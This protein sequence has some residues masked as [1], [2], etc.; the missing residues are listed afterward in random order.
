MI[1]IDFD[2]VR[3]GSA[4]LSKIDIDM[5]MW[6]IDVLSFS[7]KWCYGSYIKVIAST[8]VVSLIPVCSARLA[9]EIHSLSCNTT[10]AA[11]TR[12]LFECNAQKPDRFY[13][14]VKILTFSLYLFLQSIQNGGIFNSK[15]VIKISRYEG[16]IKDMDILPQESQNVVKFSASLVFHYIL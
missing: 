7:A 14:S 13:C 8:H 16:K 4:K 10:L 9:R 1:L 12:L 6:E 15:I 11:T 3:Y 5:W 2:R